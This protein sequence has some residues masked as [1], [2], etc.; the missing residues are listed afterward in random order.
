MP[1]LD[2]I[3]ALLQTG[4]VGVISRDLFLGLRPEQP[5][6]CLTVGEYP[7][8]AS[9]YVQ[10]IATPLHESPQ[11]QISSRGMDYERTRAKAKAAWDVLNHVTNQLLSG[12]RYVSIRPSSPVALIGRDQNG[13]VIVG[14]NATVVKEVS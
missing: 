13:R 7:G 11:I 8:N 10:N 14:F 2:E 1:V 5:D 12:T 9:T 4:G 6:E 3:G